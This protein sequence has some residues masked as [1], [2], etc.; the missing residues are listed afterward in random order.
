MRFPLEGHVVFWWWDEEGSYRKTDGWSRDMSVQGA[1]VLA[2]D[3]P[4]VGAAVG[5][6]VVIPSSA[7]VT[8]V[9]RL[10]LAGRVLRIE[11]TPSDAGSC[12]FAVL[13]DAVFFVDER[14]DRDEVSD[15]EWGSESRE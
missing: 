2:A 5:L 13:G 4:P 7:R 9:P 3:C 12:G 11:R 8:R 6:T 14:N 15:L 10:E 1:Y